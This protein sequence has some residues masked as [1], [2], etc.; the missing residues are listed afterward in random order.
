ML[1]FIF[2]KSC[3]STYFQMHRYSHAY[4]IKLEHV[5]MQAGCIVKTECQVQYV[6]KN[7]YE[8]GQ[9]GGERRWLVYLN[10]I[11]YIKADFV[12]LSGMKQ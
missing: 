12:I 5:V 11:D 6:V 4:L 2:R 10:E 9:P 3:E 1:S 8:T 7:Q